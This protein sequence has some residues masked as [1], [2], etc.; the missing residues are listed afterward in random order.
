MRHPDLIKQTAYQYLRKA[1]AHHKSDE[2]LEWP[3]GRNE[4]GYGYLVWPA[5]GRCVKA[6][7]LAFKLVNGRW[8]TPCGLHTCDNPPC[9]NPRHIVEGTNAENVA[10][11]QR[12]GRSKGAIGSKNSAA[13]VTEDLVLQIRLESVS[14]RQIDLASK[15]GLHRST[16]RKILIGKHW[17]HVEMPNSTRAK[18][19]VTKISPSQISEMIE[20]G[21]S[22]KELA[23]RY[24]IHVVTV[25]RL[26]AASKSITD[27]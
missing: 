11:R 13:K 22:E 19:H 14:L 17:A 26:I 8:P 7:R 2:C 27:Y 23:A 10:D 5:T 15:Y 9:F 21:L 3:F 1:V 12:K 20:S 16:I 24:G 18:Y 6:Y 4:S 25:R